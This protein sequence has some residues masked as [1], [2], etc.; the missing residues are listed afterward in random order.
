[1]AIEVGFVISGKLPLL[2]QS[3]RVVFLALHSGILAGL[4]WYLWRN[5]SQG[6]AGLQQV[7]VSEA[8]LNSIPARS[9]EF[10]EICHSLALAR[11]ANERRAD[12]YQAVLAEICHAAEELAK[13]AQQGKDGA[14]R[15]AA[16][17]ETI[18]AAIEQ[19]S[20]SVTS[21]AE[22]ARAA[23]QGADS[24]YHA[25]QQGTGVTQRLQTE[26]RAATQTVE[27][28]AAMVD[29]LGQRSG[30]IRDLV[31]VINAIAD[32]TN[33]LAL[34]AA[35]EAARAGE[36]GRGFAVVADEVRS[37]AGRTREATEEISDLA[38][39]TQQQVGNAIGAMGEVGDSV[40]RC[41]A[42]TV[43][44]DRSLQ[45]IQEQASQAL[46]LARDIALALQEQQQASQDIARN[47]D[48]IS[49]Q[50][51]ILNTTIDETAQ[52]AHHLKALAADLN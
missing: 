17:L 38:H 36:Q 46:N 43:E 50:T 18:A 26:M 2:P 8:S 48:Q 3:E 40:N 32:Q 47:T 45:Q 42:M 12:G 23:E 41:F 27:R 1:M 51:Q 10:A 44:A 24:S 31:E 21:V 49:M 20:V 33:L 5:L 30:E 22:H 16:N 4:G 52:T 9:R 34:N 6:F 29:S 14:G 11:I 39:Q 7:I 15:Q 28:A 19:M 35:I 25:S 37:L 13:S